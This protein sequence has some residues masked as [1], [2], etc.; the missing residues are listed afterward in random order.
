MGLLY[1]TIQLPKTRFPKMNTGPSI[2]GAGIAAGVDLL[3]KTSVALQGRAI[4][5]KVNME[6]KKL[7]NTINSMMLDYEQTI[8]QCRSDTGVL[9]IV[10]TREWVT[11]NFMT[12]DRASTF[13]G[14]HLGGAG[15]YSTK[16]LTRYNLTPRLEQNAPQNWRI[17]TEYL[18]V[19]RSKI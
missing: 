10:Y 15:S 13:H 12:G 7:N 11:P 2:R 9:V 1:Q 3:Q 18:W 16:V 14:I 17:K 8:H 6:L 5:L 4:S 19:T